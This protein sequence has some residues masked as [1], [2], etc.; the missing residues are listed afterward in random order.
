MPQLGLEGAFVAGWSAAKIVCDAAGK[1]RDY[2]KNEVVS[3]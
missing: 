2:L 1:K 3:A